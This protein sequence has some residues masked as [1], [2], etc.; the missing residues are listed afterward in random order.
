MYPNMSNKLDAPWTDIKNTIA[1]RLSEITQI[2]Y[3]GE[4]NRSIAFEKGVTSWKNPKCTSELLG[5]TTE[6]KSHTINEILNINRDPNGKVLPDLIIE[7]LYNWQETSPVDFYVDFETL[8]DCFL[9]SE[10]DLNN[11]HSDSNF[12]FMIGVGYI[13]K[14]KWN[15]VKFIANSIS[16]FEENRI[17]ILKKFKKERIRLKN[18]LLPLLKKQLRIFKI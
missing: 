11:S 14:N 1:S 12:I 2:W 15:F 18:F 4:S 13:F 7:N 6:K 17:I 5:I 8:N 3:V 16:V 9:N 10:F